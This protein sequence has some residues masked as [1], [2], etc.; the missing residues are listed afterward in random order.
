MTIKW[1]ILQQYL[2][3]CLTHSRCPVHVVVIILNQTPYL[4]LTK[5]F[6]VPMQTHDNPGRFKWAIG[7]S[8]N[9]CD[10]SK[11]MNQIIIKRDT[12]TQGFGLQV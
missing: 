3:Q 8:E 11:A 12:W 10:L 7:A 4:Q 5:C 1:V 9:L 2:E 6:Q